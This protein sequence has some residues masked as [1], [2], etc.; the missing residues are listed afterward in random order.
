MSDPHSSP[1]DGLFKTTLIGLRF[2][3][4]LSKAHGRSYDEVLCSVDSMSFDAAGDE[5]RTISLLCVA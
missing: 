3:E 1:Y 5:F 4:S 2:H